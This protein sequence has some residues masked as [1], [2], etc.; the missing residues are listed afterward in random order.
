MDLIIR[1]VLNALA[2]L[3]TSYLI[4]GIVVRD[5]VAALWAAAVI[6]IVNATIRPVLLFLTLPVRFL[7]LGLFTLVINALLLWAVSTLP[8]GFEVRGFGAA[9]WGAIVLSVISAV[10]TS[11]VVG[12]RR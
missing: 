3:A 8:L 9:F 5:F 12:R 2:L 11:L 4:S 6:G 10:L 7:T 1:W